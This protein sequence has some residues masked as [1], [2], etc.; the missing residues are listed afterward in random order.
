MTSRHLS[1]TRWVQQN[2]RYIWL[3][4]VNSILLF[5][6]GPMKLFNEILGIIEKKDME[7]WRS[8]P[9]VVI[10]SISFDSGILWMF[11]FLGIFAGIYGFSYLHSR[12]K[13]DFYHSQPVSEGNR[14]LNIYSSGLLC[15][16]IPYIITFI[17]NIIIVKSY[18]G[19]SLEFFQELLANALLQMLVYF[20]A[21]QIAALMTIIT[22]NTMYSVVLTVVA[23]L[24]EI[25]FRK[26]AVEFSG[27]FFQNHP[28]YIEPE[29]M[30][31]KWSPV[32]AILQKTEEFSWFSSTKGLW[33]VIGSTCIRAFIISVIIGVLAYWAYKKRNLE[34]TGPSLVFSKLKCV[35]KVCLTVLILFIFMDMYFMHKNEYEYIG[36][37]QNLP[38]IVVITLGLLIVGAAVCHVVFEFLWELDIRQIRKHIGSALIAGGCA[39]LLFCSFYFDWYGYDAYVPDAKEVESVGIVIENDMNDNMD[40]DEYEIYLNNSKFTC[41]EVACD[42]ARELCN[43]KEDSEYLINDSQDVFYV[44]FAFH[45]KDGTICYRTYATIV[46]EGE[47]PLS[48]LLNS[49]E[50]KEATY[51]FIYEE[52]SLEKIVTQMEDYLYWTDKSE[53]KKSLTVNSKEQLEKLQKALQADVEEYPESTT[54]TFQHENTAIGCLSVKYPMDDGEYYDTNYLVFSEYTRTMECLEEMGVTTDREIGFTLE[55]IDTVKIYTWDEESTGMIIKDVEQQ[56]E[57]L[58]LIGNMWQPRSYNLNNESYGIEICFKN[59]NYNY[60]H[61]NGEELPDWVKQIF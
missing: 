52:E 48:E 54:Y 27:L 21:Y 39:F 44:D 33:E 46:K 35:F 22:G 32:W 28:N 55:T 3:Y 13:V 51:P 50:Y 9:Q 40:V 24:Y 38:N 5:C 42:I 26:A 45:M 61:F 11:M 59:G 12:K 57:I 43:T 41:V 4:V 58:A 53:T 18:G 31:C 25:L 20:A 10:A 49:K 30:K 2:K 47:T 36:N 34:Y 1:W 14:F 8:V 19:L 23:F 15:C 7:G 29:E 17:I 6:L 16:Y 37:I 60:Y 56:K